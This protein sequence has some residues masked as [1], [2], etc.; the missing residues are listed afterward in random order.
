MTAPAIA[1]PLAAGFVYVL[2]TLLI[3]RSV[4]AGAG[5]R[6]VNVAAN[7]AMGLLMQP[8]WLLGGE[9]PA[10]WQPLAC[11]AVFFTGQCLTF[12][13]L[14]HGD[15]SVATPLM[16]T[17]ILFVSGLSVVLL[18]R[19]TSWDWWVAVALSTA[20]VI[21][22]TAHPGRRKSQAVGFTAVCAISSAFLFALAD[23]LIQH[24][25]EPE[26]L[27]RFFALMFS[28]NA[29]LSVL[30]FLGEGRKDMIPP[31]R[32]FGWL[33]GSASLLAIQVLFLA[34]ALGIYNDATATNILYSSRSLWSVILAWTAGSWFA[35]RDAEAGVRVMI[36]RL[37][38]ALLLFVAILLIVFAQP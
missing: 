21:L 14:S 27:N 7:L 20:A 32:S 37:A 16:G 30:W 4:A 9:S 11:A 34:I 3:K 29:I 31:R 25:C 5:S 8:L 36:F 6:H 18:G 19:Q 12:L 33:A 17:K 24:W 22:V 13:A 23:L 10:I 35:A 38:G 1:L 2:A 28:G 15:V 26:T